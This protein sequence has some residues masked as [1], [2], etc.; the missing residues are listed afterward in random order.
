VKVYFYFRLQYHLGKRYTFSMGSL[1]V[2]QGLMFDTLPTF[3]HWY[4]WDLEPAAK[5][6]LC[7]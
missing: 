1:W 7:S 5:W 4:P 2:T 3:R 6:F